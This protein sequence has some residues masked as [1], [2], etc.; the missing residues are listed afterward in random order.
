MA[1]IRNTCLG[2]WYYDSQHSRVPG[3]G[4]KDGCMSQTEQ[5]QEVSPTYP[6]D[7]QLVGAPQQEA[8]ESPELPPKEESRRAWLVLER[9]GLKPQ[10]HKGKTALAGLYELADLEHEAGSNSLRLRRMAQG[11]G[12]VSVISGALA[13]VLA[14]IAGFGSLGDLVGS[15]TAAWISLASAVAASLSTVIQARDTSANL[16]RESGAWEVQSDKINDV[17]VTIVS[18]LPMKAPILAKRTTEAI[19][20]LRRSEPSRGAA[21]AASTGK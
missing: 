1:C 2:V 19:K 17:V 7:Q 8:G 15:S 20:A 6:A 13:A 9:A 5:A 3:F 18:D 12:W 14:A 11:I 16:R 21:E 10:Q 4:G